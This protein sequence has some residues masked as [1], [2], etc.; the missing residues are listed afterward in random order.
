MGQHPPRRQVSGPSEK[1]LNISPV[2]QTLVPEGG[3]C[4]AKS[5]NEKL[6]LAARTEGERCVYERQMHEHDA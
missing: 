6:T 1:Q 5:I 2:A 3:S 4:K